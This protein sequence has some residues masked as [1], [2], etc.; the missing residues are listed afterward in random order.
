MWDIVFIKSA[1]VSPRGVSAAILGLGGFSFS[2][3]YQTF[4]IS[5][6]IKTSGPSKRREKKKKLC[7]VL[8]KDCHPIPDQA[9]K[10]EDSQKDICRGQSSPCFMN[11]LRSYLYQ[12]EIMAPHLFIL[13]HRSGNPA[14]PRHYTPVRLASPNSKDERKEIFGNR[15]SRL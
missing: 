6:V 5:F 11:P 14:R 1:L 12:R 4:I 15:R 13:L 2:I 3:S 7:D 10:K 9:I 8:R